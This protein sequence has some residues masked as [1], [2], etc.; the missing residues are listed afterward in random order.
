M[1]GS[2]RHENQSSSKPGLQHEMLPKRRGG[3]R[4]GER[5][6]QQKITNLRTSGEIQNYQLSPQETCKE[7]KNGGVLAAETRR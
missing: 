6:Q 2:M 4:G 3:E 1:L 7:D 5:I